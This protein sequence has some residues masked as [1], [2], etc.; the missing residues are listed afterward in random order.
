V[1]AWH[2]AGPGGATWSLGRL[3][4]ELNDRFAHKHPK[5]RWRY[6]TSHP[7]EMDDDLI[8][9]HRDVSGLMPFLHLPIQSGSDA[10]LK[11]MN[12]GHRAEDYLRIVEKLRAARPDIA[13]TSDF[14]TG[15]PGESDRDFEATLQLVRDVGFAQAYSFKYSPR[16]G[17]PGS[18]MPQQV[19]DAVSTERL[20]ALQAL[21]QE[22]SAAFNRACV[23]RSMDVLVER[24]GRQPGQ[25]LGRSP[26]MQSVVLNDPAVKIGDFITVTVTD[27]HANSLFGE[28]A[29]ASREAA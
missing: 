20:Y 24:P 6:T 1:N 11:A 21:L 22:Q 5:L 3:L 25:L 9:A 2:G 28:I 4:R 29:G 27:G 17:T 14:I 18:L 23:G 8:A 12:R 7:R 19:T 10:I 16:P 26:Y 15:F 13:L